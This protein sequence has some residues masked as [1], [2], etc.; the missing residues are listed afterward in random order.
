MDKVAEIRNYLSE[1]NLQPELANW[2]YLERLL[3]TETIA[4]LSSNIEASTIRHYFQVV[5]Y[6]NY[7]YFTE[8]YSQI[9]VSLSGEVEIDLPCSSKMSSSKKKMGLKRIKN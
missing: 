1:L 8:Y 2:L 6:F 9:C 4:L 7:H 5:A 3:E